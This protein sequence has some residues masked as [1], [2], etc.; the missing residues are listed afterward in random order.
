MLTK[1]S[2]LLAVA[3]TLS[4]TAAMAD[5]PQGTT[6]V[7]GQDALCVIKGEYKQDLVLTSDNTYVL[8]G[9]VFVGG[10]N[11]DSASLFIQ[12][13]TKIIGESGAD[14]LVIRR[15]SKIFAEGT[16]E[17]PIV[18]TTAKA[19]N[20][21]RGSW[22]GL[23]INGNAP[24]NNCA[25]ESVVCEAEGEGNTGLYG[26]DNPADDSG[27]LKYVRVEFAGFEIT[28]DNELNGIAFQ[29]VGSGT[30]VDYV[31]V[32]MNADDGVE[33][34]GGTVNVKHVLL[35]G[36]KDDSMDWVNGWQGK[37]QFVVVEQYEDQAN[38]GIEADNLSAAQSIN[39]RSN[40]TLANLTFIGTTGEAA[41]GGSGMLLRR[42]TGATIYNAII[43]GFKTSC[44][45]IDDPETFN[46]GG[47]LNA[48][49]TLSASGLVMTNSIVNCP[50]AA[51]FTLED[52][53][54]W[55][56]EDWFLA[57]DKNLVADPMLNGYIPMANSPALGN[58]ITPFDFFFD[59]VDYS[60]A[61]ES[62]ATDWTVGWT[63]DARN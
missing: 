44:I 3:A 18:F 47:T 46:F 12:P 61:I 62:A 29:G 35:T 22:G 40:P 24:I 13:G 38:N 45:D 59:L 37:A 20:R 27:V 19:E 50:A 26:G 10:D 32:H 39:P 7:S 34:F 60:G 8:S 5:C 2:K 25:D 58:G 1:G 56:T 9:G 42:G 51:N 48:D 53:D 21:T 33:F 23:I 17:A 31:Q 16:A 63:T 6:A 36:N 41:S 55:N 28:P 11:T 57:Q 54:G 4:A 49:G 14:Y 30:L 52:G 43:T 15:G